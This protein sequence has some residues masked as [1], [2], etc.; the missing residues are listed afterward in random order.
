MS[1]INTCDG[2]QSSLFAIVP[3]SYT[4]INGTTFSY[5]NL[6][7]A[8]FRGALF[9]TPLDFTGAY[10]YRTHLEGVDL[11]AATGIEQWQIDLACG[12]SST[13]LPP[14]VTAPPAW[15]CEEE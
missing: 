13:K 11:S 10:L 7:R 14:G 3:W 1:L 2:R 9:D 15:G 5:S 8:D 6:A 12:D 4:D